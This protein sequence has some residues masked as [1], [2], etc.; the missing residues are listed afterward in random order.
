MSRIPT[1]ATIDATPA[2][3][4]PLPEVVK[5]QFGVVPSKL[6]L[7]YSRPAAPE[8]C[9]GLSGAPNKS[10]LLAPTREPIALAVAEICGCNYRLSAHTFFGKSPADRDDA[11]TTANRNGASNDLKADAAVR[12][13]AKIARERGQVSENDI[14]AVKSA[15]YDDAQVIKIVLHVVLDTWTNHINVAAQTDVD[16]PVVTAREAAWCTTHVTCLVRLCTTLPR[17]PS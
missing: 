9:L 4:R 7:V 8:G 11:E 13:A 15:G 17:S 3:S 6:R 16:F 5:R 2:A 14:R 1:P 10:A 12:F